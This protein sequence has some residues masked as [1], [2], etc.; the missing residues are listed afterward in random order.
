MKYKKLKT[1]AASALIAG[2]A[3]TL[4]GCGKEGIEAEEE[5]KP[6]TEL[7]KQDYINKIRALMEKYPKL[8]LEMYGHSPV[9]KLDDNYLAALA[10]N[11]IY[12]NQNTTKHTDGCGSTKFRDGES[13]IDEL[14][15]L[16]AYLETLSKEAQFQNITTK[17]DAF[18]EHYQQSL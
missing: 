8:C 13:C 5:T 1:L 17:T 12:P 2:A 4:S 6:G 18:D 9:S 10:D 15:R 7:V 16:Y 11:D 3:L 14:K